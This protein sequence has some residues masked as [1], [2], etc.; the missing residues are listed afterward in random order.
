MRLLLALFLLAAVQLVLCCGSSQD[1]L[2]RENVDPAAKEQADVAA[3]GFTTPRMAHGPISISFNEGALI[4]EKLGR[5]LL[6][7]KRRSK[8]KP[9]FSCDPKFLAS[10]IKPLEMARQLDGIGKGKNKGK[11]G[12]KRKKG[13]EKLGEARKACSD[14]KEL[15][16]DVC[17]Y[18]GS[19]SA[20]C[21]AVQAD[22][23]RRCESTHFKSSSSAAVQEAAQGLRSVVSLLHSAPAEA[24]LVGN[25]P[26]QNSVELREAEKS[27]P[28]AQGSCSLP[29]AVAR[30]KKA[31]LKTSKENTKTVEAILGG[32]T[33]SSST[34]KSSSFKTSA[35]ARKATISKKGKMAGL[36]ATKKAG[37]AAYRACLKKNKGKHRKKFDCSGL[38]KGG[39]ALRVASGAKLCI[40]GV[41]CVQAMYRSSRTNP[42]SGCRGR[43]GCRIG[44]LVSLIR[45]NGRSLPLRKKLQ[46]QKLVYKSAYK[47]HTAFSMSRD[48]KCSA[49]L[50]LERLT[51][52][53]IKDGPDRHKQIHSHIISAS[54]CNLK[55]RKCAAKK[56]MLACWTSNKKKIEKCTP[57]F[58]MPSMQ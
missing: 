39:V 8:Q 49:K 3:K 37:K 44:S 54:I 40:E 42:S 56:I 41:G 14:L 46:R 52:P 16:R 50:A 53:R 4:H 25:E 23:S 10:Q 1:S 24:S 21:S 47:H 32:L 58:E 48:G 34:T 6:S 5:T 15:N 18:Y 33:G 38:I 20:A 35:T 9:N 13:K 45:I 17:S 29:A 27:E 2:L 51:Q 28:A 26:E 11:L 55:S 30:L 22:R 57:S 43:K 36:M 31:I 12:E 19:S 7:A